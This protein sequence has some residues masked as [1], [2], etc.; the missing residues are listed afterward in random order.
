M[1][2]NSE[3]WVPKDSV[4]TNGLEQENIESKI[5]KNDVNIRNSNSSGIKVLES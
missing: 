2:D 4:K 5:S 1:E 3:G